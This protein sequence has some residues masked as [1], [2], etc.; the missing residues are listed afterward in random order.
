MRSRDPET[1]T[2][3]AYHEAGHAV[4]AVL[5]RVPFRVVTISPS[6]PWGGTMLLSNAASPFGTYGEIT[7]QTL[8]RIEALIRTFWGGI[9]AEQ[10]LAGHGPWGHPSRRE[11]EVTA[12]LRRRYG[13]GAVRTFIVNQRP[14]LL[15]GSSDQVT[16][17]RLANHLAP[18]GRERTA[19]VRL[20]LGQA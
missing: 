8:L 6:E 17:A 5:S 11:M 20:L 2:Q 14:W 16:V 7:R 9:A 3:F 10:L 12:R 19:R 1:A 15:T 4:M 18:P 13:D